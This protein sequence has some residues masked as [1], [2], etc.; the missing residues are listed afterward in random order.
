MTSKNK[1]VKGTDQAVHTFLK[2]TNFHQNLRK[3][4]LFLLMPR[5]LKA[6]TR[7]ERETQRATL[8]DLIQRLS[9]RSILWDEGL[10]QLGTMIEFD[11][12]TKKTWTFKWHAEPIKTFINQG[13][14]LFFTISINILI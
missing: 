3:E 1:S 8:L 10:K 11:N 4:I 6:N 5:T 9:N 2:A 14:K 7:Q 13:S 12:L